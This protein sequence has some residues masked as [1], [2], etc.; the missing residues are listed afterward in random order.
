MP[1]EDSELIIHQTI[2]LFAPQGAFPTCEETSHELQPLNSQASSTVSLGETRQALGQKRIR[3]PLHHFPLAWSQA[4]DW[5]RSLNFL[6]SEVWSPPHGILKSNAV[7]IK[8]PHMALAGLILSYDVPP[9]KPINDHLEIWGTR[10]EEMPPRTHH[11]FPRSLCVQF[12]NFIPPISRR[13]WLKLAKVK[14]TV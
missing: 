12:N 1:S 3:A 5:L 7:I 13:A 10:G 9:Q 4:S 11:P 2:A 14:E 8:A 6:I